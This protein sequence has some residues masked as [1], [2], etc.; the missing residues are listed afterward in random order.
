MG[1]LGNAPVTGIFIAAT[2]PAAGRQALRVDPPLKIDNLSSEFAM[3]KE[4]YYGDV[5]V[6]AY[7]G[8][9]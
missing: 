4:I 2:T 9:Y 7:G 5:T 8:D 1:N 3:S 6:G